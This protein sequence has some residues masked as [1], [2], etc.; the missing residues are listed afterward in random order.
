MLRRKQPSRVP[1]APVEAICAIAVESFRPG[2]VA[3]MIERYQRLPLDHPT[4]KAFPEFFRALG[5]LP[6]EVTNDGTHTEPGE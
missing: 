2:A 4:V 5:P 1:T 6:E 3:V